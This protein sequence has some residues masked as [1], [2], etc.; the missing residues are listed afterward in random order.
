MTSGRPVVPGVRPQSCGPSGRR[1]ALAR[2]VTAPPRPARHGRSAWAGWAALVLA[3]AAWG[4]VGCGPSE[5]EVAVAIPDAVYVGSAACGSC[6]AEIAETYAGHAKSESMRRWTPAR[7]VEPVVGDPRRRPRHRLRVPRAGGRRPTRPG[8]TPAR[9]RR[10]RGG[11]AR[12]PDGLDRRERDARADLLR[13]PRRPP[14]PTPAHVVHRGRGGRGRGGPRAGGA[15]G[16]QPGLRDV[17]PTVRADDA[18]AVPVLPQ[19]GPRAGPGRRGR[20]RVAP[21][22]HRVRAVP[23]AGLG[24]RR[25]L[26]AAYAAPP[27]PPRRS[28]T[29]ARS[30]STSASTCASRATSTGRSTCTARG[31]RRSRTGRAAR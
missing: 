22:G 26:P 10:R 28:S 5:P 17:E 7:R 12:P 31:S 19:R 20:L 1:P 13:R 18:R 29:S 21:R 14:R 9:R 27:T 3:V 4:G 23:R 8:R 6:H 15:V 25:C 11:P 24:P 2:P 16:P 30:R